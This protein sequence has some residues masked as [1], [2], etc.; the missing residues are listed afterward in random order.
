MS[1]M[2]EMNEIVRKIKAHHAAE[3][4]TNSPMLDFDE[5]DLLEKVK[6][7]G[8]SKVKMV[9]EAEIDS[10]YL[11]PPYDSIL[12]SAPNPNALTLHE[13][14]DKILTAEERKSFEEVVRP[15]MHLT[16]VTSR[17]ACAFVSAVK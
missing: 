15:R 12:H 9:Y 5:R 16:P 7:A 13:M 10:T 8:F 14:L 17:Q 1:D 11:Q 6:G 3:R 4:T 2:P